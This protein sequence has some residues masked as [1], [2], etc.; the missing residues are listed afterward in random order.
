MST[1]GDR[2][3]AALASREVTQAALARDLGTTRYRVNRWVLGSVQPQADE[4]AEICRALLVSADVLLG[5]REEDSAPLDR[6][7][8]R[9]QI[10]AAQARL[11]DALVSLD[12]P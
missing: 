2:L 3:K 11:A 8:L 7:S 5:L 9:R 12:K 6:K 1:F 10:H 4:I